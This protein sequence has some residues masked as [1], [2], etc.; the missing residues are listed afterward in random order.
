[1]SRG[2][3]HGG[4]HQWLKRKQYLSTPITFLHIEGTHV[5]ICFYEGKLAASIQ[6]SWFADRRASI[7]QNCRVEPVISCSIS[8]VWERADP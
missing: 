5:K 8:L 7:T 2:S 4:R 3:Y 6:S 1:M